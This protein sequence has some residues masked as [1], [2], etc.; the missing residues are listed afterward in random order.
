MR[1]NPAAGFFCLSVALNASASI[2]TASR[3]PAELRTL[4]DEIKTQLALPVSI[5]LAPVTANPLLVSIEPGEKADEFVLSFD[6]KFL[7]T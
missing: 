4:V 3:E 5:S 6:A 7:Q 1:F 2:A